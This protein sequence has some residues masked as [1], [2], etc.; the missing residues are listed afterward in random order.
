MEGLTFNIEPGTRSQEP[1]QLNCYTA[2]PLNSK[3]ADLPAGR[4]VNKSIND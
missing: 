2:K 3:S 1:K 4:Q